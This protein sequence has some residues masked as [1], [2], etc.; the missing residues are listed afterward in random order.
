[1]DEAVRQLDE[2]S[3]VIVLPPSRQTASFSSTPFD[4]G[5][6]DVVTRRLNAAGG[7]T[8][9]VGCGPRRSLHDQ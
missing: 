6:Y 5:K 3:T 4:G 2:K 1:M 8:F 7:I 9:V